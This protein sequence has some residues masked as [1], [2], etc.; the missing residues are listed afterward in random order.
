MFR[1]NPFDHDREIDPEV[2]TP[3]EIEAVSD[4]MLELEEEYMPKTKKF[5]PEGAFVDLFGQQ[6]M[7]SPKKK[8]PV[9]VGLS[10]EEI[11]EVLA[12]VR[13]EVRGMKLPKRR[14]SGKSQVRF[15]ITP[16]H[17][18]KAKAI[19]KIGKKR[20]RPTAE[21]VA[22]RLLAKKVLKAAGINPDKYLAGLRYNKY[23]KGHAKPAKPAK[24]SKAKSAKKSPAKR[25]KKTT[26]R[27]PK[28][29]RMEALRMIAKHKR[30]RPGK[31][32]DAAYKVI[33][34]K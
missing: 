5:K 4:D 19:L 24:K 26:T 10:K 3:E 29:T 30:G 31:L 22:K 23:V 32:L 1:F 17:V 2:V 12:D 18:A 7:G 9:A 20:G 13:E 27:M 11:R 6:S 16:A 8:K 34:G 25:G 15:K 14:V 28:M 21:A 33:C